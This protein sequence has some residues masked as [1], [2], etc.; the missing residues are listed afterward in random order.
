MRSVVSIRYKKKRYFW[1]ILVT[2]NVTY[3]YSG[4]GHLFRIRSIN[5]FWNTNIYESRIILLFFYCSHHSYYISESVNQNNYNNK[6]NGN[7]K[8]KN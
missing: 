8:G 3:V 7:E 1:M 4:F 6:S 2:L 5:L